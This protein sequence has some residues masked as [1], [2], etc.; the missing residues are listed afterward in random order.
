MI[1]Q[2]EIKNIVGTLLYSVDVYNDPQY[3]THF[4]PQKEFEKWAAVEVT[5]LSVIPDEMDVFTLTSGLYA[6]FL[7]KGPASTASKTYQ[8]IYGTWLPNSDFL[9]DSRPHL[10]IM[11]E[12]YKNED[13]SSEEE[14]WIP[15]VR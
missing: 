15:V 4:S 2:R 11:G 3:F 9:L 7:H 13:P 8:Y 12:K 10:A 1:N 5:D 6:V 14:I